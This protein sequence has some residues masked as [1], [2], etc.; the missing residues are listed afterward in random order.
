[1]SEQFQWKLEDKVFRV[2]STGSY[3]VA[4]FTLKH[5]NS[6][7]LHELGNLLYIFYTITNQFVVYTD[8]LGDVQA[9]V[10]AAMASDSY[11]EPVPTSSRSIIYPQLFD[12]FKFPV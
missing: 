6:F 10:N 4:R 1:M 3:R 8:V 2:N 7:K 12:D 5:W 11:V 9:Y